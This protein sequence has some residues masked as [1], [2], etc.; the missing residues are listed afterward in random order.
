[1]K[2]RTMGLVIVAVCGVSLVGFAAG[3]QKAVGKERTYGDVLVT[4]VN[5]VIDTKNMTVNLRDVP[6]II[7]ENIPVRIYGIDCPDLTAPGPKTRELAIRA[8]QTTLVELK[9]G[10][11]IRLKNLRRDPAAFRL[12]ADVEIDGHSLAKV[13]IDGGYAKPWTGGARPKW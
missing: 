3:R 7:G 1:M 2:M 8:R 5:S 13:L 6:P 11:V 9:A 10:K 4:R 12:I